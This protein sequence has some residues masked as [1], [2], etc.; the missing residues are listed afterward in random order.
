M[1]CYR[2]KNTFG[3]SSLIF[4]RHKI[5]PFSLEVNDALAVLNAQN[6]TGDTNN[7]EI[8]LKRYRVLSNSSTHSTLR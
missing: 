4:S 8:E 1:K 7:I 3:F 6:S 5:L 2:L